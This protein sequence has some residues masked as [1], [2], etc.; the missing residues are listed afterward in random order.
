MYC[1]HL[2]KKIHWKSE[3]KKELA[4]KISGVQGLKEKKQQQ[5]GISIGKHELF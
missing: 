3:A 4:Q 5:H 2:C 1:L